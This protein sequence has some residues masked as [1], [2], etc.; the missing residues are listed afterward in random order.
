MLHRLS[1]TQGQQFSYLCA[2]NT[3][4]AL[5][6]VQ[7][8]GLEWLPSSMSQ[9]PTIGSRELPHGYLTTNTLRGKQRLCYVLQFYSVFSVLTVDARS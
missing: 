7:S 8:R 5:R 6:I 3:A 2:Y 1:L 9:T 4:T